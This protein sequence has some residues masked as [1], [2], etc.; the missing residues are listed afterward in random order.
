M[1]SLEHC[2]LITAETAALAAKAG[3]FAVPTLITYDALSK[4][5]AQLGMRPE[6]V[7]KIETVREAGLHS[8]EIMRSAGL[9][10]AFGTDLLGA[11]HRHQSGEFSLRGRFLPAVEVLRSAT[12]VA[13]DLCRLTGKAGIIEPGAYADLLL[14]DDKPARRSLDLGGP[15]RPHSGHHAGRPLREAGTRL[16]G[17]R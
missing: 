11:M 13:A 2:N 7:A 9:R 8:L 4:E 15:G 5:A 6:S 16:N 17:R 3:A 14:I 10:M 12:T 1:H